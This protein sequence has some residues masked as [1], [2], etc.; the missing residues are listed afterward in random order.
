MMRTR[1]ARVIRRLVAVT[2]L[3]PAR[4]PTQAAPAPRAAADRQ[5]L[6]RRDQAAPVPKAAA[7]LAPVR[8]RDQAAPV[9][10]AAAGLAPVRRRERAVPARTG[11]AARVRARQMNQVSRWP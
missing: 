3:V 11:P 5:A 1:T 7:G 4:L 8:R 2:G 9:P 6:L 10:K